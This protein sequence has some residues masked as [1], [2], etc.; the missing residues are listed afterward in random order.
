[1]GHEV[2]QEVPMDPDLYPEIFLL[3]LVPMLMDVLPGGCWT[4]TASATEYFFL[5]RQAHVQELLRGNYHIFRNISR[6]DKATKYLK[7]VFF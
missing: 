7:N 2:S 6:M 3:E 1:M 5:T 4:F